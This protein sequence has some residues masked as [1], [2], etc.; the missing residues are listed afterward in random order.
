MYT[1]VHV[2][3]HSIHSQQKRGTWQHGSSGP[4]RFIGNEQMNTKLATI[5][6]W[7]NL[8]HTF[9]WWEA[10]S[11][12]SIPSSESW[13]KRCSTIFPEITKIE[14]RIHRNMWKMYIYVQYL[15][16]TSDHNIMSTVM[17]LHAIALQLVNMCGLQFST[18]KAEKPTEWI[19]WI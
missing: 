9:H 5:C 4:R 7:Q 14:T 13:C 6:S 18:R 1:S 11:G 19:C 8:F 3:S 15:A 16:M 12:T 2:L 17:S 10:N